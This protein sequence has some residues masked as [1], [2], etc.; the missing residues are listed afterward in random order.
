MIFKCKHTNEAMNLTGGHENQ[1]QMSHWFG[2]KNQN[3]PF[4]VI[5][6]GYSSPGKYVNDFFISYFKGGDN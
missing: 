2:Q 3:I 4:W 6:Q 5:E 1:M